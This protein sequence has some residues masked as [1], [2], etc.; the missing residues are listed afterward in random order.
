MEIQ[1]PDWF[2]EWVDNEWNLK[3]NAPEWIKEEFELLTKDPNER[4]K[5]FMDGFHTRLEKDFEESLK[6]LNQ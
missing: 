5:E 3:P 4:L 6:K 1:K 2:D